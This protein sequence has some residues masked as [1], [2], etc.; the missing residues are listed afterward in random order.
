MCANFQRS[1]LV[2]S[3]YGM[4]SPL[5]Q[6]SA[7]IILFSAYS[8]TCHT[9]KRVA[10]Y[11]SIWEYMKSTDG[12]VIILARFCVWQVLMYFLAKLTEQY[13]SLWNGNGLLRQNAVQNAIFVVKISWAFWVVFVVPNEVFVVFNDKISIFN[14]KKFWQ[15]KNVF[16]NVDKCEL[17]HKPNGLLVIT[18]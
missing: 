18:F 9:W 5:A 8:K 10:H 14:D 13:L 11:S 1:P 12:W 2:L 7:W 17:C 4:T 15:R 3:L 6:C 16:E